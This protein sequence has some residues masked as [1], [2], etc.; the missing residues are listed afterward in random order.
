MKLYRYL[1]ARCDSL[2]LFIVSSQFFSR[3]VW[4]LLLCSHFFSLSHSSHLRPLP[5]TPLTSLLTPFPCRRVYVY[6]TR[7]ST[8][9]FQ[10]VGY[11]PL[12]RVCLVWAAVL[13]WMRS[14]LHGYSLII[15]VS[16]HFVLVHFIFYFTIVPFMFGHIFPYF[17]LM[18]LFFICVGHIINIGHFY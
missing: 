8:F 18:Y 10:V 2:S 7:L 17:P 13:V 4:V 11:C 5:L 14:H 9:P 16:S 12:G 3:K 1:S 15:L 6:V